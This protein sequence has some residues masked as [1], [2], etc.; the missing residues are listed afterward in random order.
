MLFDI[1]PVLEGCLSSINPR[2]LSYF[3]H[4]GVSSSAFFHVEYAF[5]IAR[6][7]S[8]KMSSPLI[9]KKPLNPKTNNT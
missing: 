9:P 4:I 2:K 3:C 5:N 6:H 7:P 1:P 8:E